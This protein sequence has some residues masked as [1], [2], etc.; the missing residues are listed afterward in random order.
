M[1]NH[2]L[3]AVWFILIA[4]TFATSQ[5][6]I[7]KAMSGAYPTWEA[8]AF[9]GATATPVFVAWAVLAGVNPFTRRAAWG[10]MFIRAVILFSAY[11]AFALAIATLPLANAVAIY[12]TMPFFIGGLSG[13][14]LGEKVP[15]H[16]WLA[17]VLGFIGVLISVRPG[18]ETYHPASLLALYSAFGYAIGQMLSRKISQTTDPLLIANLQSLFYFGGS[19][20][21]GAITIGL[22][23]DASSSPTFAAMTRSFVWPAPIDLS[24]MGLMGVFSCISSVFFVRAYQAAPASFVA[25]LEYSAMLFAVTYGIIWFKDYPDFYTLAGAGVVI[26]AGLFMVAMDHKHQTIG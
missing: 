7:V 19:L 4:I 16:R 15:A 11:M 10:L 20:V 14:A 25:P 21:F 23:L 2:K 26:A 9:R 18:A 6:A 22:N 24:L 5:D 17:I 13:W 1:Q 3:R 8:V 12:F